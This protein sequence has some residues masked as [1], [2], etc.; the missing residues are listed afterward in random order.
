M[1]SAG[2][3]FANQT[4]PHLHPLGE[5]VGLCVCKRLLLICE[6][7]GEERQRKACLDAWVFQSWVHWDNSSGWVATGA[8]TPTVVGKGFRVAKDFSGGYP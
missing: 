6:D 4:K 3:G 5:C 8:P 7:S 1:H 2:R